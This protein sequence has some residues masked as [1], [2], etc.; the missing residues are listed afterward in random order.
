MT[1]LTEEQQSQQRGL[2]LISA[3]INFVDW[4]DS[5]GLLKPMP[6]QECA[7]LVLKFF[8]AHSRGQN[9]FM[10]AEQIMEILGAPF[11]GEVGRD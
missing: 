10:Q 3:L 6:E 4:L 11:E 8:D 1:Q 2:T 5:E 7:Q 9:Y